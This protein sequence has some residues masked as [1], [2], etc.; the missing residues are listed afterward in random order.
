MLI[1]SKFRDYYDASVGYGVDKTVVYNRDTKIVKSQLFFLDDYIAGDNYYTNYRWDG[2]RTNVRYDW[3]IIGFC[4]K[5]Y[6]IIAEHTK[7]AHGNPDNELTEYYYGDEC[8]GRVF[9]GSK[10]KWRLKETREFIN[11]WHNREFLDFFYDNKVPIFSVEP[12]SR[13]RK[14]NLDVELNPVL[15]GIKF[16]RLFDSYSAFQEIQMFISGVIGI[17]TSNTTEIDDKN[18]IIQHGF[19]SKWSFRNPDPPKRKQ[20]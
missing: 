14:I 5:T 19:D 17:N 3:R 20:K 11:K 4:G 6:V 12:A 8:L 18:K 16:F 7:A 9:I 2:G 10:H 1:V 15:S 13:Y